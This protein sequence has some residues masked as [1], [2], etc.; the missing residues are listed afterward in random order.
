M[1]QPL[2]YGG[3]MQIQTDVHRSVRCS[4]SIVR[5]FYAPTSEQYDGTYQR[6]FVMFNELRVHGYIIPQNDTSIIKLRFI[7]TDKPSPIPMAVV[8]GWHRPVNCNATRYCDQCK[9]CIGGCRK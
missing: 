5:R 1:V 9:R 8:D 6:G 4:D 2:S 7:C 3:Y